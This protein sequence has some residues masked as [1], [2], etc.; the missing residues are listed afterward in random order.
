MATSCKA[1]TALVV[2][3]LAAVPVTPVSAEA[4]PSPPPTTGTCFLAREVCAGLGIPTRPAGAEP[5]TAATLTAKRPVGRTAASAPA[6]TLWIRVPLDGPRAE[7]LDC[8]RFL[9]CSRPLPE[10]T[11]VVAG[12]EAGIPVEDRLVKRGTG[13]ILRAVPRCESRTSSRSPTKPAAQAPV[14]AEEV[15][16]RVPLPE[17][18]VGINPANIGLTGL[19]TRLWDADPSPRSATAILAGYTMTATARP[20][21]WE[22]RMWQAG[23]TP[24]INPDPQVSSSAPGSSEQP[25][26]TYTYETPGDYT[27]TTTVVWAGSYTYAGPGLAPQTVDL[28]TTRQTSVRSYRVA[29]IRGARV[30]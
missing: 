18:G 22:W 11:C 13:E 6:P 10:F 24:N 16:R 12:G 8:G 27:I 19:T 30:G 23:D 3:L 1:V 21:Q 9:A 25:A 14:P 4:P 20:V 7:P 2:G 29:S 28:G 5:S 26:A 17:P 15:W